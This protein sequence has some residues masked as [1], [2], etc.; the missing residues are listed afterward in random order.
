MEPL[1]RIE[2]IKKRDG[3]GEA[4]QQRAR[5][6]AAVGDDGTAEDRWKV[7]ALHGGSA[8]ERATSDPSTPPEASPHATP[9]P[10]PGGRAGRPAPSPGAAAGA[11]EVPGPLTRRT[12]AEPAGRREVRNFQKPGPVAREKGGPELIP[13]EAATEEQGPRS[14][15]D[16]GA[17]NY[18]GSPNADTPTRS[19]PSVAH[20]RRREPA[21]GFAAGARTEAGPRQATESGVQGTRQGTP[22]AARRTQLAESINRI[23]QVAG[24]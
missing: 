12:S 6:A 20:P 15:Q 11:P 22:R 5:D 4:K 18:G 14:L 19:Q 8:R 23:D 16:T 7:N 3:G 21:E 24:E 10:T 13:S 1:E 9:Q 2:R 17:A